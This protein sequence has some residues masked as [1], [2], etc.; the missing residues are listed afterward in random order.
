VKPIERNFSSSA[1]VYD[2]VVRI[3]PLIAERLAK[4]LCGEPMRIL[5]I[6]CGTGALS[7]HLAKKFPE[8]ELVLTDISPSMLDVCKEK[9]RGR[10]VFR[11][12]DGEQPDPS[13]GYFDLITSSMA[14]Q[15]FS[16][17]PG[18]IRRLSRLLTPSG[19]LD[20]STLGNKNFDEWQN[21]LLK[22]NLPS[23]LHQY[24]D[25]ASFQWPA[26][27]TGRIEEEFIAEDHASGTAFLRTLKAMGAASPRAD[28]KPLSALEL[29]NMLLKTS[30]GFVATYHI[31]YC[32]SKLTDV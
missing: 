30:T 8:A 3:Q 32:F 21:L 24:P 11:V 13:L 22:H 7:I 29:K 15:W 27:V 19:C 25:A 26:G 16:D 4:R 17:L 18:G 31:L 6:G 9:L 20:F 23:G 14:M 12:M 2:R 5:E 10:G 1:V 28:Y